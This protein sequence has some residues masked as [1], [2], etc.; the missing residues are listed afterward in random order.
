MRRHA[1]LAVAVMLQLTMILGGCAR[2]EQ[3]A[4]AVPK[5]AQP[6]A[7]ET[8]GRQTQALAGAPAPAG[9]SGRAS[10]PDLLPEGEAV[11]RRVCAACHGQGVAG[12][13]KF[14]D[15]EAW[16]GRIARGMESL[17]RRALEGFQGESGVMPP[18]GGDPNL[19]DAQVTAAVR[20]MVEMSR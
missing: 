14:G 8:P 20:F 11:Y 2:Q 1:W 9:P 10:A 17:V 19:T 12:A 3:P 18:R 15:R 4:A 13:P 6:H 16:R 5:T 7:A